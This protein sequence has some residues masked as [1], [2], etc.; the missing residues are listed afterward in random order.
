MK[1]SGCDVEVEFADRDS[2]APDPE[3]TEAE[4]PSAVGHC[5]LKKERDQFNL[6]FV[7]SLAKM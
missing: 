5:G 3:V 1:S 4:D 2:K 6:R 7:S